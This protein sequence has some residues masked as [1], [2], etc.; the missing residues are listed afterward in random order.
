[1]MTDDE[2]YRYDVHGYLLLENVIAPPELEAIDAIYD[3]RLEDAEALYEVLSTQVLPC[4]F[5][6][7]AAGLPEAWLRRMKAS[8]ASSLAHFSAERMVADYARQVYTC[9]RVGL[10]EA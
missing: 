8:I 1:M 7:N 10:R 4:F 9:G 2:L 5:D 3:R 6:R